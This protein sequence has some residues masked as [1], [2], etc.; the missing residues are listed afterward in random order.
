MQLQYLFFGFSSLA[1]PNV[2][3]KYL[4]DYFFEPI[5]P[6]SK[7][8]FNWFWDPTSYICVLDDVKGTC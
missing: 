1:L 2:V 8:S 6:I 3:M 7:F 4:F 5:S